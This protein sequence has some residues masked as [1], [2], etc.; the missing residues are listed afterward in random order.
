MSYGMFYKGEQIGGGSDGTSEDVYSTEEVRIGTWIDGKPLY[1]KVIIGTFTNS[2]GQFTVGG[3]AADIDSIVTA[4]GFVKRKDDN[5]SFQI[6]MA[7]IGRE[8]SIG[9]YNMGVN[10]YAFANITDSNTAT[11]LSNQPVY[12]IVE[13]TKTTDSDTTIY[14]IEPNSIMNDNVEIE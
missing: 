12:M 13:Y 6:P 10:L 9:V 5:V 14:K 3:I 7:M 11:K 2:N 8:G 4:H 1:R